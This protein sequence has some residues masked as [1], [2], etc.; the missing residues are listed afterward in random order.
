[1]INDN[2]LIR[3]I[4]NSEHVIIPDHIISIGSN[5][6]S[7]CQT[8]KTVTIPDSVSHIGNSVFLNV[9][10]LYMLL[11]P[12]TLLKLNVVRSVNVEILKQW[13]CQTVCRE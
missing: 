13:I 6:F 4:G 2:E 9:K 8:I 5:A 12:I 3:Y 10:T 11:Y 1:M 7:R